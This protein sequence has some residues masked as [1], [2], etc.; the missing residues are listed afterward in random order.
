MYIKLLII[1]S[2]FLLGLY[3]VVHPCNQE[4]FKGMLKHKCPNLLIQKNN[5]IFLYNTK[6]ANVPGINPI[7][8][9]NLDEY[10]EFID[11]QRSQNINC[12]VLFLQQ[13]YDAQGKRVYSARSNPNNLQGG[14]SNFYLNK[15]NSKL[16]DASRDDPPYNKNSYPGHDQENQYIGL[17][18]PLDKMFNDK[19]SVSA[20]PMDTNWGGQEYTETIVNTGYYQS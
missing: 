18:T 9:N 4:G 6:L 15:K 17:N 14:L 20:N 19:N 12:P 1:F 16:L 7:K 11:W 2:V 5:E 10:T 13:N 8:F 3:Y